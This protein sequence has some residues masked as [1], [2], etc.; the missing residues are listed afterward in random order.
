MLASLALAVGVVARAAVLEGT[1]EPMPFSPMI[2][3]RKTLRHFGLIR[4]IGERLQAGR[5]PY[6][7]EMLQ[8]AAGEQGALLNPFDPS[9]RHPLRSLGSAAR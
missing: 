2:A 7:V 3:S 5:L 9:L 8:E 6:V 1:I 4:A